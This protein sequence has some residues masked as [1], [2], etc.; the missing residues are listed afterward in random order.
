MRTLIVVALSLMVSAC[1]LFGGGAKPDPGNPLAISSCPESLPP[2]SDE[3]FGG[4]VKK[5]IEVTSIYFKC[6][7]A[8]V[9]T[10]GSASK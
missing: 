3:S 6:R 10:A 7:T 2:L 8:A 4:T 9:G 1:G 5:L